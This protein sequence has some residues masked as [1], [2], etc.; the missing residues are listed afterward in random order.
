MRVALVIVAVI[1]LLTL[2]LAALLVLRLRALSGRVGSFECALRTGSRWI[3]GVASYTVH[4]LVWYESLSLSRRPQHRWGRDDLVIVDRTLRPHDAQGR[5]VIE[6][7][8]R[9]REHPVEIAAEPAAFEGLVSWLEASPP[10][11][12]S[13]RVI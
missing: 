1:A 6:A 4:E 7:R 2:A 9:H 5:P 11:A 12:R 8:C 13:H 3:A 10:G